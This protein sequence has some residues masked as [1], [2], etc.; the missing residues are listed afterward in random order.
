MPSIFQMSGS[1]PPFWSWRI[2]SIIS[3]GRNSLS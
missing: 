3:S 2:A 1:T